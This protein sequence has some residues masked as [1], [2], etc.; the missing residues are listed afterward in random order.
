MDAVVAGQIARGLAGGNDVVRG[1]GVLAVRQ[2]KLADRGPE[3]LD[4]RRP[5]RAPPPP[6][7]RPAL[8]RNARAPAPAAARRAAA[9]SSRCIAARA[10]RPRWNPADRGRPA[11]PR[12]RRNPRPFG[13]AGRPGRGCWQRPPARSGSPGR[14]SASGRRCRTG[15]PG[16]G[17]SRP[18]RCRWPPGP[19][20]R[21]RPP[22]SRRCCRPARGPGP[23]DYATGKKAEFS[24]DPP[25]ANSSMLV[26]PIKHGVGRLQPGDD[27]GVVGRAEVL[28]HPRGAGGRLA[29]R[30]EHVLDGHRQSGQPSQRLARLAAAVDLLGLRQGG[31][32]ID[33]QE[34]P[35]SRRPAARCGPSSAG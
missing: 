30:A 8:R 5:P 9:G 15:R 29:L 34:R 25:M 13:P 7:R 20:A 14:R 19:S 35:D 12:A 10:D 24:F 11:P 27:R 2:R 22:P 32:R 18:C 31:R 33:P 1:H 3:R 17:S 16:S 21:P 26:R 23:R 6:P 28:Q 4:T